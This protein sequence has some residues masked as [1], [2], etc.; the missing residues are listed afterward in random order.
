MSI[1][2]IMNN[3]M[4]INI[5]LFNK[6]I[7][8]IIKLDGELEIPPVPF[9]WYREQHIMCEF[10]KI[11]RINQNLMRE[12]IK[13]ETNNSILNNELGE[14]YII[15]QKTVLDEVPLYASFHSFYYRCVNNMNSN[16]LTIPRSYRKNI[17][18]SAILLPIEGNINGT[19]VNKKENGS[20]HIHDHA[21]SPTGCFKFNFNS[22]NNYCK[23]IIHCKHN[24]IIA[25]CLF[26]LT[27]N[28]SND[29]CVLHDKIFNKYYNK[30]IEKIDITKVN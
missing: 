17:S 12:I 27:N 23:F 7:L 4:D 26:I 9:I 5:N 15:H 30:I 25:T 20:V 28:H 13:N 10:N 24:D 18:F 21:F 29:R 19:F 6:E 3:N 16:I 2:A 22:K 8:P 1:K 11:V 14:C